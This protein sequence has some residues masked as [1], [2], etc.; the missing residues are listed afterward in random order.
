[1][2][3]FDNMENQIQSQDTDTTWAYSASDAINNAFLDQQL[4]GSQVLQVDC[5]SKMCKVEVKHE[6][7]DKVQD[8]EVLF[9]MKMSAV[10]PRMAINNT[11]N[12]D[13][14]VTSTIY[15][16]KKGSKLPVVSDVQ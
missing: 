6:S 9:P 10:L 13:G 14:S 7:R 2:A 15:L 3:Y 12:A 1:M 16:A 5:R 8:F 4:T 11:E